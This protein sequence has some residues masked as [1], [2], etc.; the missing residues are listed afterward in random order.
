MARWVL[1]CS[2]CKTEFTHSEISESGFTVVDPFT[3]TATKP[4][5]PAGGVTIVCPN[6]KGATVYVRYELLY[7]AR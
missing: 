7:R 3:L 4:E 2:Q 1:E 5:F 6:C